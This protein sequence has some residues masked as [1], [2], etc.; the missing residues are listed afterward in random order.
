MVESLSS[1]GM[2]LDRSST[3]AVSLE[4]AQN[5]MLAGSGVEVINANRSSNSP[6]VVLWTTSSGEQGGTSQTSWAKS[7]GAVISSPVTPSTPL[8]TP[9]SSVG[10]TPQSAGTR[11]VQARQ[12]ASRTPPA[13]MST[14]AKSSPGHFQLWTPQQWRTESK[15]SGSKLHGTQVAGLLMA[16]STN[17]LKAVVIM[18]TGS[19]CNS[20]CFKT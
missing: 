20:D 5:I 7:N 16:I 12:P 18:T 17:D 8:N 6:E 14:A 13:R 9:L 3:E 1:D 15:Y 11:G 10:T 4:V 2:A 19:A